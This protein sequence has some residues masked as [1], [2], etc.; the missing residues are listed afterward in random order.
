MNTM[1]PSFE[2]MCYLKI[3]IWR[4]KKTGSSYV[5]EFIKPRYLHKMAPVDLLLKVC[6]IGF[7]TYQFLARTQL[8]CDIAENLSVLSISRGH[9]IPSN[10][11]VVHAT[12]Q[13]LLALGRCRLAWK[14]T[15]VLAVT[16]P[17][18]LS[19]NHHRDGHQGGGMASQ[20]RQQWGENQPSVAFPLKTIYTGL[21]KLNSKFCQL[22]VS[23]KLLTN[24][25]STKQCPFI[26]Y[27]EIVFQIFK[28]H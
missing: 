8:S 23:T 4:P 6:L 24:H 7:Q 15:I 11:H 5:F 3:P 13:K 10:L 1:A 18:L 19:I 25:F 12:A 26:T 27:V 17:Q 16:V 22:P 9:K 14:E 28:H 2:N 20:R 21:A